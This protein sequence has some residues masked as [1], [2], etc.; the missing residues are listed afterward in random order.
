MPPVLTNRVLLD[1]GDFAEAAAREH[2][3]ATITLDHD[4][5]LYPQAGRRVTVRQLAELTDDAA[6]RLVTA[7]VRP[8]DRVAVHLSGGFDICVLACAVVRIGA[9]P[10]MLS[11][12]LDGP[13][14]TTLLDRLRRPVL[15]T[16]REKLTGSL[17][18]VDLP[19]LCRTVVS[20]DDAAAD[21]VLE[22][23]TPAA[24]LNRR[25][26]DP[27]EPTLMTHTSGTTG[28]PKLVMHSQRSLGSRYKWQR[29]VMTTIKPSEIVCLG[30]S[31]VHSRM[32][33]GLAALVR[34]GMSMVFMSATDLATI[35]D[36]LVRHRP[37][38]LE[39]HPNAFLEW[40]GL[41]S[42]P[43]RP[44]SS[45]K[46]F[47]STFDAIHP[48]TMR[49]F[50]DATD[51]RNPVFLQVYGQSECGPLA[52]RTYTRRTVI[53]ADGRCQGYP[54][55]GIT[56]YRISAR[57]DAATPVEPG[58][59]DVRTSGRALGYFGETERFADQVVDGWWRGGDVGYI[60]RWGCLHLL[61]REVDVIPGIG[62][63]L[64]VEDQLL[65]RLDELVELV[66]LPD[67]HGGAVP[68]V[69]TKNDLPLDPGRWRGA[70]ANLAP[71]ADPVQ[72]ALQALPRTATAKI[73][74]LELAR[75]LQESGRV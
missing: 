42:D 2:P 31:F 49:K 21:Q 28:V 4:L 30:V 35:S 45:V 66:I 32:Y 60:S 40:E 59:I 9:V 10:A 19:G 17:G 22:F 5:L 27:D 24:L 13:T 52:A 36:T 51:R 15:I 56:S 3:D 74:R 63:A 54:M 8:G 70:V 43:R 48:S 18:E 58:Y 25:R 20:L 46:Y 65:S 6:R 12:H 53:G 41:L 34:R 29:R 1:L 57:G 16:D 11:S 73:R 69:C 72:L 26:L 75:R 37:G 61:D 39:T 33:L 64:A 44:I 7:G 38:V 23:V 55:P 47:N 50:L 62:S 71:M 67:G 68:V 14:I